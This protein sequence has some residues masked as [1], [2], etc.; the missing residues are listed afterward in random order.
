MNEILAWFM[1]VS[2]IALFFLS[3]GYWLLAIVLI[4]ICY[5]LSVNHL[6]SDLA[7]KTFLIALPIIGWLRLFGK[8]LGWFENL[9]W[10]S[11]DEQA[12]AEPPSSN[13][14]THHSD[15]V[16][17]D[18]EVRPEFYEVLGVAF[19][20]NERELKAAWR[21]KTKQWHPDRLEGMAPELVEHANSELARINVAY[22]E[23]NRHLRDVDPLHRLTEVKK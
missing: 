5:V 3:I 12:E 22:H 17:E 7:A 14:S 13:E 18:A 16:R 20:C 9:P 6:I 2:A 11:D 1:I 23:L 21:N 4:V 8:W 10:N 19:G 15:E